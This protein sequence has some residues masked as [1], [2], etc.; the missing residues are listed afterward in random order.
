MIYLE[1]NQKC[2]KTI[3][4]ISSAESA[5]TRTRALIRFLSCLSVLTPIYSW[6]S[7][8]FIYYNWKEFES[9]FTTIPVLIGCVTCTLEYCQFKNIE[10]KIWDLIMDFQVIIDNG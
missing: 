5:R 9:I 2:F 7:G 10:V 3:G 8:A 6:F 1:L 4:I